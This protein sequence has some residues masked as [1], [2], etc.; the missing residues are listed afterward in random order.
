MVRNV[1]VEPYSDFFMTLPMGTIVLRTNALKVSDLLLGQ[2]YS[3][4]TRQQK[5]Q[6]CTCAFTHHS[7][8]AYSFPQLYPES[9]LLLTPPPLPS[10]IIL[11][12]KKQLQT[13][14]REVTIMLQH[15]HFINWWRGTT[16]IIEKI[17]WTSP[18]P[19]PLLHPYPFGV[20][21]PTV[22]CVTAKTDK[23]NQR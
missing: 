18:P 6:P 23:H 9:R 7:L 14:T 12:G 21:G 10:T 2:G 8:A 19:P 15:S 4:P 13:L 17:L 22:R 11:W 20:T 5:N 16:N 1:W 3:C